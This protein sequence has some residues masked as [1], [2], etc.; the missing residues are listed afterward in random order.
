M[1][2]KG[3]NRELMERIK[4][5]YWETKVKIRKKEGYTK[6]FWTKKGVKQVCTLS[7]TLFNLY[8]TDLDF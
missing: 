5:I 8:I 3:I 1:E 7:P 6:E 4:D 2:K